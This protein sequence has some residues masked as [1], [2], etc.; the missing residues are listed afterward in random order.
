[1]VD[2]HLL[3]EFGRQERGARREVLRVGEVRLQ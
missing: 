2:E 1:V 3:P